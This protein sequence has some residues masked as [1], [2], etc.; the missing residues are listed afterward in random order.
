[1][2]L[3]KLTAS[4]IVGIVVLLSNSVLTADFHMMYVDYLVEFSKTKL[5]HQ[6]FFSISEAEGIVKR[7]DWTAT[8]DWIKKKCVVSLATCCLMRC[9]SSE[10]LPCNTEVPLLL[11]STVLGQPTCAC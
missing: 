8:S 9:N 2:S 10:G 1:M 4:R 11:S 7:L 6:A 5:I 3:L